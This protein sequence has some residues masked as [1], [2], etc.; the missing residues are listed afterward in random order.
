VNTPRV[1]VTG[2][3]GFVGRQLCA[4]LDGAGYLVRA[5]V[6]A[7]RGLPQ[8]ARESA[9]LHDISGATDWREALS[10]VD[11][12]VHAAARVHVLNDTRSASLYNQ[13]N[14]EGTTRLAKQAAESGVR[15]FVYLSSI[16][17]NG[18]GTQRQPYTGSDT[19][20]PLD[21]YGESK[22]LAERGLIAATIGTSMQWTI[23]RPPLVY[24][25]GVR[26]NFL[27]LLKMIDREWP[28]PVGSVKN[29]RSIVSIWNLCDLLRLLL[30]HPSAPSRVWM[31]ADA[32]SLSTAQLIRKLA[33]AMHR[34][35]RLWS[36]P[37]PI[38]K[39]AAMM[40]ARR[41]EFDRLCGSLVVDVHA[42]NDM[43]GWSQ[44]VTIDDGLARTVAWYLK[45]T[46]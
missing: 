7:G 20:A 11:F 9:V 40:L 5:A 29:T 21:A 8:G 28:I 4:E 46:A 1:L 22:M 35:A 6:R 45:T 41:A 10:Q 31:V 42:T 23:V 25:P 33:N 3:T 14:V 34:R 43:L 36:V 12:V 39:G 44:P 15:R 37:T 19:P 30:E 16:K 2:A 13:T 27:R 24:G 18:E 32:E 26:A 38:L 17:V